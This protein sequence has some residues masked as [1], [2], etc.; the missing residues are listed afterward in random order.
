MTHIVKPG[1]KLQF[2]TPPGFDGRSAGYT[3]DTVVDERGGS[4]QTGFRVSR[5][6]TPTSTRSR[7]RCT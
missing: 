2:A 6:S 5:T 1:A 7:N 4:V 3:G